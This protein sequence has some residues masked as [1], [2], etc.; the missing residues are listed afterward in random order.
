[1]LTAACPDE[2]ANKSS[3]NC[4]VLNSLPVHLARTSYTKTDGQ[5]P[6]RVL[7]RSLPYACSTGTYLVHYEPSYRVASRA[8]CFI[9]E[10]VAFVLELGFV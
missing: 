5:S 6:D 9:H 10:V 4:S 2:G 3:T 8:A 1:M 7:T